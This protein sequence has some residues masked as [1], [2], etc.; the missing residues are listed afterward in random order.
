MEEKFVYV[1]F[2]DADVATHLLAQ[3]VV[4]VKKEALNS[5]YQSSFLL[6]AQEKMLKKYVISYDTS[7][8]VCQLSLFGKFSNN[9]IIFCTTKIFLEINNDYDKNN[10]KFHATATNFF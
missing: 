6:Q 4:G 10:K 8:P 5:N 9:N 3:N 2:N 7:N 1:T